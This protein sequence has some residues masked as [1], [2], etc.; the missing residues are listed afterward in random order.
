MET[1]AIAP[2]NLQLAIDGFGQVGAGKDPPYFVGI[3]Q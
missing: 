1:V 3:T 2:H